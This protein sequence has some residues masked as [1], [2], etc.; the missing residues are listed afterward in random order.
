MA[1]LSVK[2]VIVNNVV[3]FKRLGSR[4]IHKEIRLQEGMNG[5]HCILCKTDL[6]PLWTLANKG[7][8]FNDVHFEARLKSAYVP[9]RYFQ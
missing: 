6:N 5:I 8:T 1:T 4:H 7:N 9:L 3:F 2:Y